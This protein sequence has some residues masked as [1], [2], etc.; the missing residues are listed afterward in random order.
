MSGADRSALD[1]FGRGAAD[2]RL[3]AGAARGGGAAE[4]GVPVRSPEVTAAVVLLTGIAAAALAGPSV[5]AAGG[6]LLRLFFGRVATAGD[7]TGLTGLLPAALGPTARLAGPLVAAGLA[8]TVAGHLVQKG[9][10]VTWRSVAPRWRRIAPDWRG[11]GRRLWSADT[12]FNLGR[13]LV[14]VG[15]VAVIAVFNIGAA[16]R[17]LAAAPSAA[18]AVFGA[19]LRLAVQA[20]FALLVLAAADYLYRYYRERRRSQRSPAQERE[21]RRLQEG[22]PVVRDRLRARMRALLARTAADQVAG[23]DL[24]IADPARA[25]VALRWDRITMTAPVVVA[26]AAAGGVAPM[27]TAAESNGVAV[28]DHAALAGALFHRVTLGDAIPAS[29]QPAVAAILARRGSRAPGGIRW[30]Q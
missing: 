29:F 8:G 9:L 1:G 13:E 5:A 18:A 26:R 11:V 2:D 12:A 22:D 4:T 3:R 24:V 20:A 25:A 17:G 19:A 21:E 6:E 10:P 7:G 28:A 16:L 15:T 23:A 14:K 30:R 27:R